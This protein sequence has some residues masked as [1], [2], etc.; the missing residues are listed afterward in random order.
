MSSLPTTRRVFRRTDNHNPGSSKLQ[1]QT[2]PIPA[3]TPTSLLIKV[4]NISLNYRD[5]N[6]A[7]GGNP[8][9]VILHGIP[10]NDAA[11]EIVAVGAHVSTFRNPTGREKT[12]SWLA[13]DEDGVLAEFV[14]FQEWAACRLPGY[15]SWEEACLL[16]CAGV[17]AWMA[18]RGGLRVILSSSSD[19][20]PA[21]I[22]AQ[23]LSP[24][25]LIVNYRTNPE[26][27]EEVLRLTDGE[28]V[29][30]VIEVGD[31]ATLVQSMKCTRRGGIVSQVGYL[32][33][34]GKEHDGLEALLSVL[35]DR[36]IVLWSINAGSKQDMDD[37]CT[38]LD[39]TQMPLKDIIDSVE[40]F[41][42][43]EEAIEYIWQGR[44]VEKVVLRV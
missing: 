25:I 28:G 27:H 11:G 6:I 14:V 12:R 16:P 5:A 9:P 31:S 1:L 29:N 26:W 10:C 19:A 23:F 39:A 17:T 4:H 2:E 7:N 32:S 15:L 33:K 35:I 38:A 40:P 21:R 42:K 13:A 37:L 41:Q 36:R 3:L 18:L 43:A 20:K 34:S 30:L 24:P 22:S 8:W 44:Q